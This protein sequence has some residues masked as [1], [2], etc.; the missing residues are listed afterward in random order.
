M[1]LPVAIKIE[2][3]SELANTLDQLPKATARNTLLRVLKKAAVPVETAAKANAPKESGELDQDIHVGTRLT[4]RQT[5]DNRLTKGFAELHIGTALSRGMFTNFGTF[6]D[7][8][9]LWFDRAW[10]E[11]Q[12]ETLEIISKEMGTEIEKSAARYAKKL[13]R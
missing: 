1:R 4:R 7:T 11:T 13:G 9:Q 8:A 5:R 10:A 6:K 3:F 12:G 2:G